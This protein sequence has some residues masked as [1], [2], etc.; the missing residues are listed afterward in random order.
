MRRLLSS[1]VSLHAKAIMVDRQSVLIGSMNLDP[2]SRQTNTE[3]A[4]LIDSAALGSELSRWFDEAI[5]LDRSY[6]PELTT[7]GDP[8]SPLEW[9]GREDGRLQRY[10][11]E[12]RTGWWRRFVSGLLGAL[13]PEDLL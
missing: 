12:P 5:S 1:G 4:V 13:V 11:S 7:P 6:R 3:V 8:D 10:A 9:T 2:R